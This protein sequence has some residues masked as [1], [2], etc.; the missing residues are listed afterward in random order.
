MDNKKEYVS[1]EV[2]ITLIDQDI[3]TNSNTF[4]EWES[5]VITGPEFEI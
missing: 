3:I 4:E 1:P 2:E 5:E